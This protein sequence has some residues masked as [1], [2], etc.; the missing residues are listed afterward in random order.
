MAQLYLGGY[1]GMYTHFVHADEESEHHR[2]TDHW[3]LRH[4]SGLKGRTPQ[5]VKNAIREGVLKAYDDQHLP[6]R[7]TALPKISAHELGLMMA[8]LMFEVMCVGNLFDIDVFDQ[9]NVESYKIHTKKE[10]S[11]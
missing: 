4:V 2:L 11:K 7:F 3:L 6:Y 1:R 8:S 9:P 10:L 5:E